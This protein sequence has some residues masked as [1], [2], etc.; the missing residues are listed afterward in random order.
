ML[1]VGNIII[2]AVILHS[3]ILGNSSNSSLA[4]LVIPQGV[5]TV[6]QSRS[7]GIGS[8]PEEELKC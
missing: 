6:N 3:Q 7:V 1:V 5:M 2:K 4:Q 8:K